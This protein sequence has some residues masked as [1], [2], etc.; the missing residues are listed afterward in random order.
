MSLDSNSALYL[1]GLVMLGKLLHVS[2]PLFHSP[3]SW[4]K[5]YPHHIVVQIK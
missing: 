1:L 2:E 5:Y 3:M 4:D